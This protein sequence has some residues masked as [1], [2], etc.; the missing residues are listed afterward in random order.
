MFI[1]HEFEEYSPFLDKKTLTIEQLLSDAHQLIQY[2][3]ERFQP[4]KVVLVGTLL[5]AFSG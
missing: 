2:L 3:T 5:A 1:V 4:R